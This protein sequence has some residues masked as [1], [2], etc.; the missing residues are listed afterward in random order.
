MYAGNQKKEMGMKIFKRSCL[1]MGL[2]FACSS[3]KG[4]E[5]YDRDHPRRVALALQ[6][7]MVQAGREVQADRQAKKKNFHQQAPQPRV[8]KKA[9]NGQLGFRGKKTWKG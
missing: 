9:Y 5:E 8:N 3:V 2:F 7:A 1:I 6:L 4:T